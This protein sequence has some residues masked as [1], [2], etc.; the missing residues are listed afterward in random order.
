MLTVSST[1]ALSPLLDPSVMTT[2]S[3]TGGAELTTRALHSGHY[4]A[5]HGG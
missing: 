1:V 2:K 3:Y 5:H 4:P